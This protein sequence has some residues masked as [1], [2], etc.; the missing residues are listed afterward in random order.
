MLQPL[1]AARPSVYVPCLSSVF[2][3]LSSI[4][5]SRYSPLDNQGKV[6]LLLYAK[7]EKVQFWVRYRAIRPSSV[8]KVGM[9]KRR[10]API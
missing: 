4:L 5:F 1:R 6:M 3:K 9:V 8:N 10:L 2:I 7:E